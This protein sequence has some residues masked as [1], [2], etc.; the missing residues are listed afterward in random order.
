MSGQAGPSRSRPARTETEDGNRTGPRIPDDPPSPDTGGPVKRRQPSLSV[1]GLKIWFP[2]PVTVNCP[3][4]DCSAKFRVTVWTSAKQSIARH[5][6]ELH[7]ITAPVT[8][9]CCLGYETLLGTRPGA[10]RCCCSRGG[11]TFQ[12]PCRGVRE[13]VPLQAGSGQPREGTPKA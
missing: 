3:A 1:E 4:D 2:L 6:K 10:H 13:I 8:V 5:V 11:R 7:G 12:V 9:W